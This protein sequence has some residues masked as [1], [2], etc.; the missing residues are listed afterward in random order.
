MPYSLL[1]VVE[2]VP[3][4]VLVY[5]NTKETVEQVEV[6]TVFQELVAVTIVDIV[7]RAQVEPKMRGVLVSLHKLE[8]PSVK[9][10]LPLRIPVTVFKVAV[11]AVAGTAVALVVMPVAAVVV[12]QAT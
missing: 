5:A 12:V 2:V 4:V 10:L 7:Q 6:L 11:A 1:L 9:G 3:Q 8:H